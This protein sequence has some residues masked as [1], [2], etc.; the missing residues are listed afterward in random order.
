MRQGIKIIVAVVNYAAVWDRHSRSMY[1]LKGKKR[2]KS[3]GQAF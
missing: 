1:H 3:K 2:K